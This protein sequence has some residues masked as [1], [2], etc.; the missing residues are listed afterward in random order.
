MR[1]TM[2]QVYTGSIDVG[3]H[4]VDGKRGERTRLCRPRPTYMISC[5]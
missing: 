4:T 1:D 2:L 3:V 5:T